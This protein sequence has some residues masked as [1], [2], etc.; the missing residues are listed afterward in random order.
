MLYLCVY[1]VATIGTF[2]VFDVL[3][4]PGIQLEEMMTC[5]SAAGDPPY[6]A[7]RRGVSCWLHGHSRHGRFLGKF[8]IFGS[9]SRWRSRALSNG[10]LR[11]IFVALAI[12][13]V[14]ERSGFRGILYGCVAVM[15]FHRHRW[16]AAVLKEA[17]GAAGHGDLL[18]LT[19]ALGL[20][21]RTLAPRSEPHPAASR[22]ISP[23][24][25]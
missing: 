13:G 7:M 5:V 25:T 3:G 12:V 8:Q 10:L 14:V 2:A 20:Y 23:A 16:A 6:A 11:P 15:Y 18:F 1:A 4:R 21:P 19:V 17:P 9:A 24:E 22:S